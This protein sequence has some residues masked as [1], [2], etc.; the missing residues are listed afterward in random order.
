[1]TRADF[2]IGADIS[3]YSDDAT[4]EQLWARQLDEKTF[5][6][7]CIPFFIYDLALGDVVETATR[8]H[9]RYCIDRVVEGSGRFVFRVWFGDDVGDQASTMGNPRRHGV[10][11]RAVPRQT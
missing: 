2:I 5:E 7:C 8:E 3:A 1:M 4:Y 6:V 10:A 11:S 9:R